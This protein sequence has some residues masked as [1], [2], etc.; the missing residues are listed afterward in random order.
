[1]TTKTHIIGLKELRQNTEKVISA[2][3]KG[4]SFT[5]V[6]RSKPIF[7]LSPAEDDWKTVADFT[8]IKKGG[9]PL[10]EVIAALKRHA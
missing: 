9:V 8:K 7:M 10:A 6:R 1:M 3:G 4:A 5:V 2:V